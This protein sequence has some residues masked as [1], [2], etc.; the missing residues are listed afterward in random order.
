MMSDCHDRDIAQLLDAYVL[1]L[2]SEDERVRVEQHLLICDECFENAQKMAKANRL[3]SLDQ[4]LQEDIRQ[5]SERESM[6]VGVTGEKSRE[7]SGRRTRLWA[8]LTPLAVAA[9]A[10]IVFVLKDWSIKVD[11]DESAIAGENRIAVLPFAN[12]AASADSA[13]VGEIVAD[14]L[15]TDLSQSQT[16]HVVSSQYIY[17]LSSR[18][19]PS[20][21]E[22]RAEAAIKIAQQAN[23]RWLLTGA[24]SQTAPELVVSTQLVDVRNGEVKKGSIVNASGERAVFAVVDQLTSQVVQAMGK[25]A[26]VGTE[27]KR[28]VSDMT[29]TSPQAYHE[30]IQGVD[31]WRKWYYAEA[32][33]HFQKAI[34]YDSSFAMPYY[35]LSQL[36]VSGNRKPMIME[37]MKYI[38]RVGDRDQCL[39]RI[40]A[41][42]LSGKGEEALEI[43]SD[44]VRRYPDEKEPL[45]H[46]GAYEY[47]FGMY[48]K[49]VKHLSAAIALDSSFA[50]AYNQ[51]AYAYEAVGDC[52]NA[53]RTI[54]RYAALAP[55][56][57]NPFDSKGAICSHCGRLDEAIRSYRKALQIKPDFYSSLLS[58][59]IMS[60]FAQDYVTADSCFAFFAKS[61]NPQN[62]SSARYYFAV[63]AAYQGHFKE[64]LVKIDDAIRED[65]AEGLAANVP[66]KLFYRATLCEGMGD[67]SGALRTI[68][69]SIALGD[70]S[71]WP[72]K[73]DYEVHIRLKMGDK[74]GARA[75]AD[76]LKAAREK[77]RNHEVSY[78]SAEGSIASAESQ[79]DSAVA[80]FERAYV[81]PPDYY[82]RYQLAKAYVEAK[83]FDKGLPF[84]ERQTGYYTATRIFWGTLSVKMYYYLGIAYEQTGNTAK[85]REQY[86]TFLQIWKSA[87]AKIPEIEDARNRL[88]SLGP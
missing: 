24:I 25:Q 27:C 35:Y 87:D 53:V 66:N 63:I 28:S 23:A 68:Q 62:R 52:D 29:T 42:L 11:L 31:L 9:V 84:I 60:I 46:A 51:L 15:I 74:Q 64:A 30:Y 70:S 48:E 39:I 7:S 79:R 37:A 67:L 76:E 40:R 5:I 3:L 10:L 19:S 41:A 55:D 81:R 20:G 22:E 85:A 21:S 6:E 56:Q 16:L 12:L 58:L 77:S 8:V 47:S 73:A 78:W 61:E 14:L 33:A 57:A 44:F 45:Y 32:G 1:A 50:E 65:S 88:K 59:G 49:A 2:L 26:E 69:K 36:V 18:V 72:F 82:D 4:E 75:K 86:N 38:D 17:D 13:R 54:D 80:F 43:L 71:V 83:Q 34:Q